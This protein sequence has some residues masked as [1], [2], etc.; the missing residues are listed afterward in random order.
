MKKSLFAGAGLA[1]LGSFWWMKPAAH[2]SA[3]AETNVQLTAARVDPAVDSTLLVTTG[4]VGAGGTDTLLARTAGRVQGIFF[5][6]WQYARRGQTL[7]KL[8]N[9]TYVTAPRAGFLGDCQVLIGQYIT[10]KTPV[11]TLSRRSY[12]RV[13][14]VLPSGWSDGIR[15]G[16][17]ARVWAASRRQQAVMGAVEEVGEPSL[18]ETPVE[19]RLSSRAPFRLRELVN[20]RLQDQRHPLASR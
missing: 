19:I 7:V 5:A 18:G 13:S 15:A 10:A 9:H 17:S 1:V 4:L 6:G 3:L 12:L 20:V 16:D 11:A 14:V 8:T 2:V